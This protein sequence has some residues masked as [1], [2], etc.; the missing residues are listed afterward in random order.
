MHDRIIGRHRMVIVH[1]KDHHHG[2]CSFGMVVAPR[3]DAANVEKDISQ[4]NINS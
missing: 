2:V 4:K 3:D 1:S